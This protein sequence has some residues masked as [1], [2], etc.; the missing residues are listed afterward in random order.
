MRLLFSFFAL[1]A[2]FEA[3]AISAPSVSADILFLSRNSNFHKYDE[4]VASPDQK[5]NGIN[6]REA[7]LQFYADVD[8]YTRLN[9]VLA[10]APKY[11]SDGTKVSE[12]W[13]IEPE[14]AI[15]ESNVV[16]N[17]T[18]KIGKFKAAM[19]KHNMLHTHAYPFV[20]APLANVK[21]LG[22]EGLNDIG[23]SA[24]ILAPSSWFNELTFQYLRGK[25]ENEEFKSPSPGVGVGLVHWKNLF[26]LS[27]SLTFE[28][29]ASY[30][31]GGNSYRQ[32]TSLAGM[33]LTFK[34]RPVEGGKYTS[35]LWSTEYLSRQQSQLAVS[36][37]KAAG[38]TSWVQYQFAERWS[39]FCRSESLIVKDTFDP[40]G[41]PNDSWE[42]NS[43]ALQYAPSEFSS[44]KFEYNQGRGGPANANGETTERAFFIQAN[45]T[46]GAHPSHVY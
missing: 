37:E 9:L 34:W 29:G 13:G 43:V 25:G 5:P 2:S 27:D 36:D 42:R 14:E 31:K 24:A 20:E 16:A 28:V 1:L 30:A 15:A 19:G 38:L 45:F 44:Y 18:L 41:L 12:S 11:T 39:V 21:L 6:V 40:A 7:E 32:S 22:D 8:P 33:D 35:V 10:I 17:L 3:L 4:N 46:I 23:V 26:D